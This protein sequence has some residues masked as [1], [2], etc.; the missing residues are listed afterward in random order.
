MMAHMFSSAL[1]NYL[2]KL[3]FDLWQAFNSSTKIMPLT[4]DWSLLALWSLSSLLLPHKALRFP[5]QSF[6]GGHID[7]P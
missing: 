2:N 3:I 5:F 6:G 1:L 4:R 7:V